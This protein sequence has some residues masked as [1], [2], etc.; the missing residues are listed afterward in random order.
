M[1]EVEYLDLGDF[2]VWASEVTGFA[3]EILAETDRIGL[4][5]SALMAPWPVMGHEKYPTLVEKASVIAW[6]L[7]KNHALPDGNKR[8]AFLCMVDFLDRNGCK[9]TDPPVEETVEILRGIADNVITEP[10]FTSWLRQ[11]ADC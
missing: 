9:F 2:L 8:T 11:Y 4:A 10:A 7:A 5:A 6:R 1:A 3:P